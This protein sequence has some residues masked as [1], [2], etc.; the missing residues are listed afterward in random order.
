[1]KKL[2]TIIGIACVVF[3][4]CSKDEELPANKP[5]AFLF[6]KLVTSADSIVE[7]GYTS[8]YGVRLGPS[9]YT[10]V[11][12]DSLY[13]RIF[14]N[15]SGGAGWITPRLEIRKKGSSVVGQYRYQEFV[16]PASAY[17]F[18]TSPQ[19]TYQF[20]QGSLVLDITNLGTN[21]DYGK[22]VE[23]SF[24]CKVVNGVN[25][26]TEIPAWGTFRVKYY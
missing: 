24:T 21:S 7:I 5:D 10:E 13:A 1:M 3:S 16:D 20:I 26:T 15:E 9:I 25:P 17:M 2:I 19:L 12:G 22:Y 8:A 4:S 6:F 11:R 14:H 18:R 23:G